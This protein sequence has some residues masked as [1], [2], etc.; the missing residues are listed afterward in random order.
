M[1]KKIVV[2]TSAISGHSQLM[3]SELRQPEV[4][5]R[6]GVEHKTECDA[7]S[8][9]RLPAIVLLHDDVPQTI[10]YGYLSSDAVDAL[11]TL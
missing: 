7:L 10:Q 4:D 11:L 1:V 3:R 5:F 9:N 2:Y 6:D 8:I